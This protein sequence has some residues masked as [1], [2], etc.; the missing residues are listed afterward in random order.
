MTE[1]IGFAET[2]GPDGKPPTRDQVAVYLRQLK[3]G[4]KSRAS[5]VRASTIRCPLAGGPVV[6]VSGDELSLDE[7]IDALKEA[8]K[9][10]TKAR[11][12]GLDAKTAQA[13][14]K[15]VAKAG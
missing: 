5:R 14:W 13:V 7:A 2:P 4:G 6:T 9:A 3:T 1:A 10:M 12:T 15:D 8:L 11:D